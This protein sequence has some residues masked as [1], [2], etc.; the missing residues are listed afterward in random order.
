MSLENSP[1]K[2]DIFVDISKEELAAAGKDTAYN[3]LTAHDNLKG[4]TIVESLKQIKLLEDQIIRTEKHLEQIQERY[5]EIL[6]SDNFDDKKARDLSEAM[7]EKTQSIERFTNETKNIK[8]DI[9]NNLE[10]DPSFI[11]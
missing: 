4:D 11:N 7:E 3:I 9:K 5:S 1:K 10:E 2:K 8:E 6:C